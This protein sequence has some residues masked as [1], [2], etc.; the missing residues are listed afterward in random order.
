MRLGERRRAL[1]RE[2]AGQRPVSDPV[3]RQV[4]AAGLE[5]CDSLGAAGEVAPGDVEQRA[6]QRRPH[7]RLILGERVGDRARRRRAGRR[8]GSAAARTG[9]ASVKLQPTI[10]SKPRSRIASSARRRSRCG[11]VSPPTWPI[12]GRQG[13]WQ[14]LVEAVDPADLLDQVDLAG[15]VAVAVGRDL[16]QEL[17]VGG[18]DVEPEPL[19]VGDLVG[20]LHLHPEQ[21][22]DPLL[23]QADVMVGRDLGGDV[24]RP[25]HQLR[26]AELDEQPRSDPICA[27]MQSSGWSCFSNRERGLGAEAERCARCGGC[28]SR[29]SSRP[30]A[31]P[32]SSPRRPR[33]PGRP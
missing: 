26:A 12:A 21:L 8:R 6:E 13:R 14:V 27:R 7:H 22:P 25:G 3:R 18:V 30:R 19:E 4:D 16:D 32:G 29:S 31:A 10:S 15:D 23:A 1:A 17:A 11:R 20:L 33:R 24:D 2:V 28:W 5:Q 9:P